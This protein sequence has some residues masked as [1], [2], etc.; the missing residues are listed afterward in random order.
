[1]L[2]KP[3]SNF[4]M[5]EKHDT[6][7]DKFWCRREEATYC[8]VT[9]MHLKK[10]AKQEEE[11]QKMKKRENEIKTETVN[12]QIMKKKNVEMIIQFGT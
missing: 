4:D 1:M 2:E 3:V 12:N 6:S 7:I 5:N 8:P 11:K 9:Y 10:T